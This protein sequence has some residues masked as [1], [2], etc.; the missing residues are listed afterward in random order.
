MA[1]GYLL[2][3]GI[4]IDCVTAVEEPFLLL[5]S[6]FIVYFIDLSKR[7]DENLNS[8]PPLSFLTSQMHPQGPILDV[9]LTGKLM[10]ASVL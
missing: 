2:I 10:R 9:C 7:S 5:E 6:R 3:V 8:V 1:F 4:L